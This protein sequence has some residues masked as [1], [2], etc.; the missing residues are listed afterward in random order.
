MLVGDLIYNKHFGFN[1]TAEIYNYKEENGV[2][3]ESN[4]E[5]IYTFKPWRSNP[6]FRILNMRICYVTV[7]DNKLIIMAK[8]Q[9]GE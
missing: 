2:I 3:D 7:Y 6:P 9:G 1:G 8:N 5:R 4:A